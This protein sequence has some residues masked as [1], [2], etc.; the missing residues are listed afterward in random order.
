MQAKE[1]NVAD[2]LSYLF[3]NHGEQLQ[4][5]C[6]RGLP[7]KKKYFFNMLES[8]EAWLWIYDKTN[9]W[10]VMLASNKTFHD[11]SFG[12][13]AYG[14]DFYKK[15]GKRYN[16]N[17]SGAWKTAINLWPVPENKPDEVD[18]VFKRLEDTIDDVFYYY[19]S[20]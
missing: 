4:T 1:V 12:R 20:K 8:T 5:D 13:R 15:T 18:S 19:T 11:R 9:H 10:H 16:K 17:L 7:V 2:K 14:A 6:C 3:K